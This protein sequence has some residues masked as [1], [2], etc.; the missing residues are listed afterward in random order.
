MRADRCHSRRDARQNGEKPDLAHRLGRFGEDGPDLGEVDLR[1]PTGRRLEAA[2]EHGRRRWPGLALEARDR[3]AAAVVA[4]IPD[5]AQE[6]LGRE[7]QEL[8]SAAKKP[9]PVVV[10]LTFARPAQSVRWRFQS[11]CEV[12]AHKTVRLAATDLS[13][14]ATSTSHEMIAQIGRQCTPAGGRVVPSKSMGSGA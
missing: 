10:D 12:Q 4:E 2:L 1:L 14:C 9:V 13:L 3:C 11:V 7:A 6:R 8:G 5:L